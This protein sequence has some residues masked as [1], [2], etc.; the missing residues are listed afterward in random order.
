MAD[1]QT[2]KEIKLLVLVWQA[3]M[4]Q[5]TLNFF[6]IAKNT[7][8][9]V[10]TAF[11]KEGKTSQKQNSG[12]K[13]KLSDKGRRTLTRIVRKDH[14]NTAPKITVELNDHLE[15]QVSSKKK[16]AAQSQIS[17]EGV[18]QK[19]ILKK[20]ENYFFYLL[21]TFCPHLSR[22]FLCRFFFPTFR[23]NF[24]SGLLQKIAVS[25]PTQAVQRFTWSKTLYDRQQLW[26]AIITGDTVTR[27]S[28]PIR[29]RG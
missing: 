28:I 15:N 19:I 21:K 6:C 5:K 1:R 18:N 3:L 26:K 13:R 27:L 11:E 25:N 20:S 16:G 10:M 9:K 14:K 23:P 4:K 8:S 22:V 2:L 29:G 12:R 17:K 7:V 24:T